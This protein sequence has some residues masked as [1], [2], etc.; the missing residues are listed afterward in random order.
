MVFG[1][2]FLCVVLSH[3]PEHPVHFRGVAFPPLYFCLLMVPA[4]WPCQDSDEMSR[5]LDRVGL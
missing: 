5:N 2:R 1:F 4:C 3:C